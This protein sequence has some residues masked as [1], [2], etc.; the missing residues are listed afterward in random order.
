[1]EGELDRKLGESNELCNVYKGMNPFFK[2]YGEKICAVQGAWLEW[3]L[4]SMKLRRAWFSF[5]SDWD[6]EGGWETNFW[7]GASV[8]LIEEHKEE[9]EE[10]EEDA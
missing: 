8:E 6:E 5:K 7:E 2:I 1:M 3:H 9:D 10:E 4:E